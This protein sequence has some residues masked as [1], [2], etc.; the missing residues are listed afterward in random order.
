MWPK[1]LSFKMFQK[2]LTI[3]VSS[4]VF[5]MGKGIIVKEDAG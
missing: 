5:D 1:D 4:M 3:Q 2:F